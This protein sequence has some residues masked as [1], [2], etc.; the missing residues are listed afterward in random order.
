MVSSVLAHEHCGAPWAHLQVPLSAQEPH[1][2]LSTEHS[3]HLLGADGQ[4]LP[5]R[6]TQAEC[7][8]LAAGW[9]ELSSWRLNTYDACSPK[10]ATLNEMRVYSVV[11]KLGGRRPPSC[12][13][14]HPGLLLSG[15]TS[16]LP[17]LS[18]LTFTLEAEAGTEGPPSP[19]SHPNRSQLLQTARYHSGRCPGDRRAGRRPCS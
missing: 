1:P 11:G 3:W 17:V 10:Q 2:H 14:G 4:E 13:A 19:R 9:G 16:D 18:P 5:D 6:N 8:K 12:Q 7:A 15:N